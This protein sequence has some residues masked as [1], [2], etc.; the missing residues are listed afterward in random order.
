MAE[1]QEKCIPALLPCFHWLDKEELEAQGI[2]TESDWLKCCMDWGR[3]HIWRCVGMWASCG[4]VNSKVNEGMGEEKIVGGR[5]GGW[6]P[7]FTKLSWE[8]RD[9]SWGSEGSTKTRGQSSWEAILLRILWQ[10]YVR[11]LQ[12]SD[13]RRSFPLLPLPEVL[14]TLCKGHS[15]SEWEAEKMSSLQTMWPSSRGWLSSFQL[16]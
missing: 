11:T 1:I 2:V 9:W 10:F 13:H 16:Y 15:C 3:G 4:E 6:L 5:Q 14:V 8:I 7:A 12:W